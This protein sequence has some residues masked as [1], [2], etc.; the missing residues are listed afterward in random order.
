MF[1][2]CTKIGTRKVSIKSD[3]KNVHLYHSGLCQFY[4]ITRHLN[5]F[6][7]DICRYIIF[8]YRLLQI[9]DGAQ[10]GF[11]GWLAAGDV[12]RDNQG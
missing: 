2:L 5:I 3:L 8:A 4:F 10:A 9:Y 6:L 11:T 7:Y 1:Q 12:E